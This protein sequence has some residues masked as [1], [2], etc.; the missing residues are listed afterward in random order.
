MLKVFNLSVIKCIIFDFSG[1]ICSDLYFQIEPTGVSD[2]KKILDREIFNNSAIIDKWVIGEISISDVAKHL[3]LYLKLDAESLLEVMKEGCKNLR[4]NKAILEFAIQQ[5]EKGIKTAIVTGNLDIFTDI[6][7]PAHN[8][9]T[10]FGVIV[11]SSDYKENRREIL[12]RI[13]FTQIGENISF[14]N[15]LLIDDR[16]SNIDMFH[17]LGGYGYHYRDDES[18]I[19]DRC[20]LG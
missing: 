12:W 15:S 4:I 3:S 2:W 11:N 5:K 20:Q 16:L 1:T 17:S 14:S 13:A 6:V 8:L 18:F 19:K 9:K 10:M 7:V